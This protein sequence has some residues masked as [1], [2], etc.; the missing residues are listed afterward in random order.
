MLVY[1]GCGFESGSH[2]CLTSLF[3]RPP[4][5]EAVFLLTVGSAIYETE[6]FVV[7]HLEFC[8]AGLR[9]LLLF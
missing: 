2:W 7:F 4:L 1:V 9:F 5:L 3:L 8:S 6:V